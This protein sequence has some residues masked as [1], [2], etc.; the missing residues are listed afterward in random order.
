MSTWRSRCLAEG[1][2]LG[3]V[4]AA[5]P[6]ASQPADQPSTNWSVTAGTATFTMRDVARTAPPVDA[7]PI[8]WEGVGPMATVRY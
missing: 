3:A 6:A 8:A 2:A 4:L 7:S 5:S 1:V